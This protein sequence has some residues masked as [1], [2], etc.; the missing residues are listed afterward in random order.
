MVILYFRNSF[1][2]FSFVVE[3]MLTLQWERFYV[4]RSDPYPQKEIAL[5]YVM[6]RIGKSRCLMGYY[7]SP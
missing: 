4:A 2:R 3:V 5:C 1:A 6:K 7:R